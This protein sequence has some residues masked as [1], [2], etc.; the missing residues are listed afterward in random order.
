MAGVLHTHLDLQAYGAN[1][2]SDGRLEWVQLLQSTSV[3]ASVTLCKGPGLSSQ[4][5]NCES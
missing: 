1:A 3:A 5:E 4:A 2:T